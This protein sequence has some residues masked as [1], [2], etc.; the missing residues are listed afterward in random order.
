M[1]AGAAAAERFRVTSTGD[2][3]FNSGYGSVATAYGVRAWTSFNPGL[4]TTV[5]ASGGYSASSSACTITNTAHGFKN[6]DTVYLNF[7]SGSL[8]SNS[9]KIFYTISGVTTDTFQITGSF[10]AGSGLVSY[11]LATSPTSGNIRR[12][13]VGTPSAAIGIVQGYAVMFENALPDNNYAWSGSAGQSAPPVQNQSNYLGSPP[14]VARSVWQTTTSLY[15]QAYKANND[16][17]NN[18]PE[19]VSI[20]VVR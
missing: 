9:Y 15:I 20:I 13:S 8:N 14:N 10:T 17:A 16:L 6:G 18:T 12:I 2:F 11:Y 19:N 7:T 5:T 1:A 3:K 4:Y